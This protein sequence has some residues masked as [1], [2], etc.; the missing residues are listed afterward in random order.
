LPAGAFL[1]RNILGK[2]GSAGLK[3]ATFRFMYDLVLDKVLCPLDL[4]IFNFF[5]KIKN[6]RRVKVFDNYCPLG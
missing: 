1:R 6:Y 4:G 3:P 5:V 2:P